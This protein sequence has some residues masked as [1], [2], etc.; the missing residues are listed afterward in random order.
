[1]Y[2]LKIIAKKSDGGK[3]ETVRHLGRWYKV[4]RRPADDT[5]GTIAGVEFFDGNDTLNIAVERCDE[6][7]ITTLEGVTVDTVSRGTTD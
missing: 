2:A 3:L 7:Y 4:D 6:A 5:S 1:M